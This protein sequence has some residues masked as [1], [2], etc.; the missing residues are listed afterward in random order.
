MLPGASSRKIDSKRK[1]LKNE[2]ETDSARELSLQYNLD[3]LGDAGAYDFA[4]DGSNS[5]G[6]GDV[7]ERRKVLLRPSRSLTPR[8]ASNQAAAPPF[9]GHR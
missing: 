5:D 7:C 1:K 9:S 8:S 2:T 4:S 6:G 3:K